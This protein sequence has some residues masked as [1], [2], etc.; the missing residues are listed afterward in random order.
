MTKLGKSLMTAGV[1]S[2]LI[3]GPSCGQKKESSAERAGKEI[4]KMVGKAGQQIEKAGEKIEDEQMQME[5]LSVIAIPG[6]KWAEVMAKD[7]AGYS[8][9]EW[10][11]LRNQVR[12][13]IVHDFR[14]QAIKANKGRYEDED[15]V[16]FLF[17]SGEGGTS[18]AEDY[19][20]P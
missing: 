2:G 1:M 20:C 18:V 6:K 12:R 7:L 11:E 16:P 4:D 8:V 3:M 17:R 10:Q 15:A 14:Y 13:M 9:H 19:P 5:T